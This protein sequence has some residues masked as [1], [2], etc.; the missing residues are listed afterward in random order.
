MS[1]Q[2][3][4]YRL[5]LNVKIFYIEMVALMI[6]FFSFTATPLQYP[7]NGEALLESAEG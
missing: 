2:S 5:A 6:F 3:H 7:R 1:I 4:C